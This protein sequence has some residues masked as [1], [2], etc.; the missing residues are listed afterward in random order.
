MKM[1]KLG[2]AIIAAT[3]TLTGATTTYAHEAGDFIIRAGAATVA[4]KDSPN[5]NVDQISALGAGSN[6]EADNDTQLGLNF[7]YMLT[8]NFGLEVL[9]ASPFEHDIQVSLSGVEGVT[10]IPDGKYDVGSTKQLPP[11]V[12]LQYYMLDKTSK[13]RPYV[14]LGINYTMFFDQSSSGPFD[15]LDLDDSMGISAQVGVDVMVTDQI[16]FNASAYRMDI[17]TD[18]T[19]DLNVPGGAAAGQTLRL[20]SDVTIDPMVYMVS[21]GYKL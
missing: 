11:T 12:S 1:N 21:V 17:D 8:D 2:A 14:G 18:A 13:V 16:L 6:I 20:T 15:N 10:G 3:V 9:A 4:P 19:V 7:V 5:N